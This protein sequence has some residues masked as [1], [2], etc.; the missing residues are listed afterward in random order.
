MS[1]KNSNKKPTSEKMYSD[2]L[3]AEAQIKRDLGLKRPNQTKNSRKSV[4]MRN[5]NTQMVKS[6]LG[7]PARSGVPKITP[8]K[9]GGSIVEHTE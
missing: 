4:P 1:K 6:S 8:T 7:R 9:D 3:R 2:L 5:Q